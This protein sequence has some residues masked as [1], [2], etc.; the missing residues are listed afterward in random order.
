MKT[1]T[2]PFR[3]GNNLD[4][5]SGNYLNGKLDEVRVW[6]KAL[7]QAEIQANMNSSLWGY[8]QNLI[9]Y[10][11]FNDGAVADLTSNN[12]NG[13]FYGNAYAGNAD[14][15]IYDFVFTDIAT[16]TLTAG[17]S[18]T[19]NFSFV[20]TGRNNATY[21]TIVNINSND[22]INPI[23]SIPCTL[24]VNGTPAMANAAEAPINEIISGAISGLTETTVIII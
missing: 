20:S 4:N 2:S 22:P 19:V 1:S 24:T 10:W 3:M 6:N 14:A 5:G 8:E 18:A 15:P 12:N 16:D 21:T 17:D 7:S 13:T 23:L 11:N 9:G